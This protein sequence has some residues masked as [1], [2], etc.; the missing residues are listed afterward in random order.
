MSASDFFSE[1]LSQHVRVER[2][3]GDDLFQ[4]RFLLLERAQL[5][6][7]IHAKVRD[8]FFQT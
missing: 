1:R 3:V 8:V 7:F 5:P 6:Q 4:A 2:E